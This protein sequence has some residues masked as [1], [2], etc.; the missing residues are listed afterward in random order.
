ML[1]RSIIVPLQFRRLEKLPLKVVVRENSRAR[2]TDGLR[3]GQQERVNEG[4]SNDVNQDRFE[5]NMTH[6]F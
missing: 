3:G 2:V 1:S 4:S 5:L 6:A